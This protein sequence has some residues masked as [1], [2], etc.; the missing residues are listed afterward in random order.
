M[1]MILEELLGRPQTSLGKAENRTA[2]LRTST[3][4]QASAESWNNPGPSRRDVGNTLTHTSNHDRPSESFRFTAFGGR[5]DGL[6]IPSSPLHE[7]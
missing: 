4:H 3:S 6:R 7:F 5:F 2:D 1:S